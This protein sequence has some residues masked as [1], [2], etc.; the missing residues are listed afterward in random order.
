MDVTSVA[1]A[2][3]EAVDTFLQRIY[4][5]SAEVVNDII[6]ADG[7]TV[8]DVNRR[9]ARFVAVTRPAMSGAK[10]NFNGGALPL[11][12]GISTLAY[13]CGYIPFATAAGL[14]LEE[15]QTSQG[16]NS[17]VDAKKEI[18]GRAANTYAVWRD[19]F[20]HQ[21]GSGILAGGQG[22]ST[23]N[24]TTTMTFAAAADTY[25][26]GRL[27]QGMTVEVYDTTLATRRVPATANSL[28]I[29][30]N[31]NYSTK[32]IT[33]NQSVT[34]LTAGDVVVIPGLQDP[35][36]NFSVGYSGATP[37]P[38]SFN[39]AYPTSSS[40]GVTGDGF[41]HGLPYVLDNTS[42]HYFY[43]VLKSSV[44]ELTPTVVDASG[45]G[46]AAKFS[47]TFLNTLTILSQRRRN[48]EALEDWKG[49]CEGAQYIGAYNAGFTFNTGLIEGNFGPIKD[50]SPSD[51]RYKDSFM[52]C[53]VPFR[54]DKRMD[55][56]QMWL[57]NPKN[58]GEAVA[59]K[60]GLIDL[61]DGRN[62]VYEGRNASGQVIT[63]TMMFMGDMTDFVY[64]DPAV[65]GAITGLEVPA[66]VA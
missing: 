35:D 47:F 53:G 20:F 18:F 42:S 61:Q 34:S 17:V 2:M 37:G 13:F 8:P 30:T 5:D 64:R 55:K 27:C 26:V 43:T 39:V 3:K 62:G 16:K 60:L 45:G 32:T 31:I 63:T 33:F 6:K 50:L 46:A 59:S 54:K 9:F 28:L 15:L 65:F 58:C 14:S 44:P 1:P 11:P 19:I 25:G 21:D 51:I 10:T 12:A 49:L 57:V 4:E 66:S 24:G 22:G 48:S 29:I 40:A 36:S 23:T 52:L 7:F 56:S 38:S 41:R